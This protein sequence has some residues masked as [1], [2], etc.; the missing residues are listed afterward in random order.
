M[1]DFDREAEEQC[2]PGF[3]FLVFMVLGWGLGVFFNL[4]A[5]GKCTTKAS[6]PWLWGSDVSSP[7]TEPNPGSAP[8]VDLCSMIWDGGAYLPL[9][10]Y[11][12][13]GWCCKV[14]SN[15]WN[16][17][18]SRLQTS[19]NSNAVVSK[20]S[21]IWRK[22][23]VFIST[24]HRSK[25]KMEKEEKSCMIQKGNGP[26]TVFNCAGTTVFRHVNGLWGLRPLT[27]A[28]VTSEI[29]NSAQKK[30]PILGVWS[31]VFRQTNGTQLRG[32]LLTGPTDQE[33]KTQLI[34]IKFSSEFLRE[35]WTWKLCRAPACCTLLQEVLTHHSSSADSKR[36]SLEVY[37]CP[38]I[39]SN[40]Q[41]L[42]VLK[43]MPQSCLQ[44][45]SIVSWLVNCNQKVFLKRGK[46]N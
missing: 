14:G 35:I 46:P 12:T 7:A 38:K 4:W 41:E 25:N 30:R 23:I 10:E 13:G 3:L 43:T 33:F 16:A 29:Q 24:M 37:I 39:I 20:S 17:E 34:E 11:P 21:T 6:T 42:I 5:L 9:Y 26:R 27:K 45:E 15:G 44:R 18:A 22:S 28:K 19:H 8:S 31:P 32:A 40:S 36:G 1:Q 2:R